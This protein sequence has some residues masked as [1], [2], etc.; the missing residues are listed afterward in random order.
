MDTEVK[1]NPLGQRIDPNTLFVN[2]AGQASADLK[3]VEA[4][5][6]INTPRPAKYLPAGGWFHS[7]PEVIMDPE[8]IPRNTPENPFNWQYD[9]KN[10][11]GREIAP[12]KAGRILGHEHDLF[13]IDEV[14]D[15][16]VGLTMAEQV[17]SQSHYSRFEIEPLDFSVRNSLGYRE[18]NIVKY[19]CRHPFKGQQLRDLYKAKD[20]L[21]RI[22][23]DVEGGTW[24]P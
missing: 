19:V 16:P 24:K 23:A 20:Y 8:P 11:E 15:D 14:T 10:W 9:P 5:S 12:V 7:A 13:I 3:Q 2:S 4:D 17:N 1:H 22:I 21:L 18:G 6:P